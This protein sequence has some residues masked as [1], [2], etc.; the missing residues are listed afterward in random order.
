MLARAVQ[1]SLGQVRMETDHAQSL[2]ARAGK[3]ASCS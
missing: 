1:C 3:G 2:R